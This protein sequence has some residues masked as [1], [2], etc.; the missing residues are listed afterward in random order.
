MKV[1]RF[2]SISLGLRKKEMGTAREN[3]FRIQ[4]VGDTETAS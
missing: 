4:I 1:R 3:A 2:G